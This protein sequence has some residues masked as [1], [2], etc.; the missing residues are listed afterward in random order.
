MDPLD[1]GRTSRV[2]FCF[3]CGY[4]YPTDVARLLNVQPPTVAEHLDRLLKFKC[5]KRGGKTGKFESYEVDWSG[6]VN[7][8][9]KS[10]PHL[11]EAI[12]LSRES[13]DFHP[14]SSESLKERLRKSQLLPRL[15]Q[16]YIVAASRKELEFDLGKT[17][18]DY[19]WNFER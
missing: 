11:V 8:A 19:I 15:L 5:L 16:T 6:F 2:F 7:H 4:S 13:D 9:I 12:T 3:A 18:K 14:I 17:V 10:A 1:N